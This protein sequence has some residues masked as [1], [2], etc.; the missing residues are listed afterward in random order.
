VDRPVHPDLRTSPG[1]DFLTTR[2][3]GP[4]KDLDIPTTE[5]G[6]SGTSAPA[7]HPLKII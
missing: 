4:T 2:R 3:T 1:S 6:R 7:D 5:V